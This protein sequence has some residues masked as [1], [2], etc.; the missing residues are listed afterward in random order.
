MSLINYSDL[1]QAVINFLNDDTITS[2]VPDFITLAES[3]IAN[4]ITS[5][6]LHVTTT[7]TVD[8][9]TESL[10]DDF[11]SMIRM[12]LSGYASLDYM[13]PDT[14]HSTYASVTSGQPLVFTVEGNTIHFAP[15]PDSTYTANYTYIA[16]P[17]LATDDTNRLM[18]INPDIYLF[19]ALCE[20]ADYTG[21]TEKYSIYEAKYQNAV[22]SINSADQ[23]KGATAI[24]LDG[25][26]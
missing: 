8:S 6:D 12:N 9:T 7:L 11:K 2:N 3:R 21:D 22:R 23:F 18:T 4:D 14:F 10:P 26:V 15:S 5:N 17:D 1:Q 16:R 25:V 24:Y 20:A 19:G 13:P